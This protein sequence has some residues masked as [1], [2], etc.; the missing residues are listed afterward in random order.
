MPGSRTGT[1]TLVPADTRIPFPVSDQPL[2]CRTKSALF[3]IEDVSITDDPRAREK[4]TAQAK[5]A[6]SGCPVVTGCLKWALANPDLTQT[7][8]WAATTKRDRT[9][10]RKQLVA[11]H[12]DD[13]VGVVADQ[14][15]EWLGDEQ[16]SA[17]TLTGLTLM[18][19]RLYD[20]T[21]GRFLQVDSVAGGSCNS[22]DY[23]CGD[24]VN[25]VDLDG[26]MAAIA[27]V[28]LAVGGVSASTV[29]TI[30]GVGAVLAIIA[31][32]WWYG[33]SWAIHKVQVLWKEAKKSGKAKGND[34]PNFAKGQR[35][36]S[37]ET[38]DHA[39]DRVMRHGGYR[40]PYKKV[41]GSIYNKVRKYLSRN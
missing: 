18:G 41:P 7:G 29:L 14:D 24:P 17:E 20:P 4:A 8:V 33:K 27:L 34:F 5:Q 39:T 37:S 36:H 13:W 3:A 38:L 22:Y 25:M 10:L 23:V 1:A 21:A 32:I 11:R 26:R 2:A 6:C 30:I 16:R 9:R 40:P 31:L 28:G 12:G 15:H 35:R 19:V